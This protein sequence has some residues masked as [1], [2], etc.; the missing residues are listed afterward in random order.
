MDG[1]TIGV[2]VLSIENDQIWV[3]ALPIV[4]EAGK[5]EPQFPFP[6]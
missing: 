3:Q 1:K 4:K 5:L 2:E 6:E